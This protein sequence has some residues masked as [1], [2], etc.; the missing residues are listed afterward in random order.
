MPNEDFD[1]KYFGSEEKEVAKAQEPTHLLSVGV[2]ALNPVEF[3]LIWAM[4]DEINNAITTTEEQG[5]GWP[6]GFSE[7]NED[8]V[9]TVVIPGA[10]PEQEQIAAE[11]MERYAPYIAAAR[12]MGRKQK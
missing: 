2:P 5:P 8:G 11:I 4:H 6:V 10:T 9:E 3:E 12:S 7:D 1:E